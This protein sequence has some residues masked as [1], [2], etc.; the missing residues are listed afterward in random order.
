M[1][2]FNI[3]IEEECEISAGTSQ[4]EWREGVGV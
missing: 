3:K 4:R 1:N 2:F